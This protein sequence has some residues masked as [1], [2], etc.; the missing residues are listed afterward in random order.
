MDAV[1]P[2]GPLARLAPR[3]SF[4]CNGAGD[5]IIPLIGTLW[6]ANI[7]STTVKSALSGRAL[8]HVDMDTKYPGSS[9]AT[10]GLHGAGA[11]RTEILSGYASSEIMRA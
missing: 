4:C 9:M 11:G 1:S 3:R 10:G 2:H 5:T 6:L 7:A 8:L